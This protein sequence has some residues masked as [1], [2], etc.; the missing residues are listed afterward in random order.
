MDISEDKGAWKIL[1]TFCLNLHFYCCCPFAFDAQGRESVIALLICCFTKEKCYSM[2]WCYRCQNTIHISFL[3]VLEEMFSERPVPF[4][5]ISNLS[6][7]LIDLHRSA[8]TQVLPF[9]L[10]VH[11]SCRT[12]GHIVNSHLCYKLLRRWG[13]VNDYSTM[14]GKVIRHNI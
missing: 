5:K 3:F 13:R 7:F 2:M 9:T 1:K 12:Q 6:R 11:T 8:L 10:L 14:K 4:L